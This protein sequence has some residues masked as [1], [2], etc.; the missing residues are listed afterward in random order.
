MIPAWYPGA[1]YAFSW[2]SARWRAWEKSG[3]FVEEYTRATWQPRS[4]TKQICVWVRGWFDRFVKI[5]WKH[6]F[7]IYIS[8]LD[9]GEGICPMCSDK[10]NFND[11]KFI[12]DPSPYLN[13]DESEAWTTEVRICLFIHC[14]KYIHS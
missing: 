4:L 14:P 2:K 1:F 9:G 6:I 7:S 10:I 12:K 8:F 3:K 5:T 11:T 13:V